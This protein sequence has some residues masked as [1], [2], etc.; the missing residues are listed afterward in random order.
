M[1][2]SFGDAGK[3]LEENSS[4]KLPCSFHN[5][6]QSTSFRKHTKPTHTLYTAETQPQ[7]RWGS[8]KYTVSKTEVEKRKKVMQ[9]NGVRLLCH[10]TVLQAVLQHLS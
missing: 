8:Q 4:G 6:F 2:T 7:V 1:T 5:C 3:T 9:G 10:G